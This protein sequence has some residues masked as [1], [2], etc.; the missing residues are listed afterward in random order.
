MFLFIVKLYD[1]ELEDWEYADNYARFKKK[2]KK[3]ILKNRR[4]NAY[5]TKQKAW[6]NLR[7]NFPCSRWRSDRKSDS[8]SAL[9]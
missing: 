2:K 8:R 5:I 4:S 7:W 6:K 1:D 3:L 9:S